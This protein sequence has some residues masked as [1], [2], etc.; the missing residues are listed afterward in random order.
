VCAYANGV[1]VAAEGLDFFRLGVVAAG[2]RL[3]HQ[4]R[5]LTMACTSLYLPVPPPPSFHPVI[6]SSSTRAQS[7][8]TYCP[9][10]RKVSGVQK[11]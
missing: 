4:T 7:Q 8:T 11:H 1:L 3:S 5:W 6:N 9:D 2:G 10:S